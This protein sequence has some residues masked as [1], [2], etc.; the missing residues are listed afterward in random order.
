MQ[1]ASRT[2]NSPIT[3]LL[4]DDHPFIRQ[5]LRATIEGEPGLKVVAEA[6][7]GGTA[8][9]LIQK[10]RPR[11]AILDID[12]PKL[13]G[14]AV[15]RTVRQQK[16]PVEII[17][18]TIHREDEFFKRALELD[19]KGYVTKDSAVTDI[20]SAIHAVVAGQHYA[21]PALA[22]YLVAQRRKALAPRAQG[23]TCLSP[24]E[25]RVLQL[26]AEYKT[27]KEI[28]RALGVSPLTVKTHRQNI[29]VKLEL[30]GSH[31]LMKFALEHQGEL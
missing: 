29:C 26:I 9:E 23:L 5:S 13:D 14:F 24:T 21:S 27:T 17:F 4:A 2:M 28:A 31:G 11:V 20:L 18:L 25:R 10:L 7:D 19:A 16:L 12:M 8:L 6:A 30:Q 15:A 3:L 22:S 1:A